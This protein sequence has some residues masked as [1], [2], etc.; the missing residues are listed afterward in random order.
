LGNF[1]TIRLLFVGRLIIE[2]A[3]KMAIPWATSLL[4]FHLD[5]LIKKGFVIWNYFVWQLFWLLFKKLGD[6]SKSS[7][8][9]DH[10]LC[11]PQDITKHF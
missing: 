3:Q 8:H 1:S 6:F 4:H 7:G 9:P 10:T 5:K 2:I 11:S